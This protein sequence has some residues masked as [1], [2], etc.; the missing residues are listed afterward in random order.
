MSIWGRQLQPDHALFT[1]TGLFT[2]NED[3]AADASAPF[4]LLT[5]YRKGINGESWSRADGPAAA[6]DST[7]R[8]G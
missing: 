6:D 1:R 3:I 5:G 8:R 7:D 2:A 4:N